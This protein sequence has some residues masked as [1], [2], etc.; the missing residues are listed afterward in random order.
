LYSVL[1]HI[2]QLQRHSWCRA[3]RPYAKPAPTG[4]PMAN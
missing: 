3:Y 4:W 2:L 1:S